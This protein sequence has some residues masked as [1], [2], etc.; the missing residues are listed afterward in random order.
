[1]ALRIERLSS[2]TN[3]RADS[4][5]ELIALLRDAVDDGASVGFLAPFDEALADT[6]WNERLRE[7]GLGKR[8][9]LAA[10]EDDTIVGSVQLV[11][12]AQQN[13]RHRAEVQRLIVRRDCRKRGIAARLM[14]RLD[15]VARENG[16]T[17]LVLNTRSDDGPEAYYQRLGYSSA[18]RIPDFACNPDG[19]FNT[20]TIMWRRL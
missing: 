9:I 19:T 16:R 18:G 7:A 14:A 10:F 2:D 3:G 4:V 12:A 17:L 1:M 20:T 5:R 6:Y 15:D 11:F 13:G 8:V